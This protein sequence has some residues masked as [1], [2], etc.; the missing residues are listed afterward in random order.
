MLKSKR[1]WFNDFGDCK[2]L[3][4]RAL[5]WFDMDWLNQ[6]DINLEVWTFSS[7]DFKMN[8]GKSFSSLAINCSKSTDFDDG[9]DLRLIKKKKNLKP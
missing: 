8:S 4:I 3:I 7:L 2:Q 1:D 5:I 9:Q 6:F